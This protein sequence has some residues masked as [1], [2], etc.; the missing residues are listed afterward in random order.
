MEMNQL[1]NESET[2][3]HQASTSL[4]PLHAPPPP[5]FLGR[6]FWSSRR[7]DGRTNI[8]GREETPSSVLSTNERLSSPLSRQTGLL[9]APAAAGLMIWEVGTERLVE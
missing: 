6:H 5:L 2:T 4:L 9:L 8:A 3:N 7:T 1:P